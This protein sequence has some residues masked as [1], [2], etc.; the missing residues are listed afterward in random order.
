MHYA[1]K[2]IAIT[3]TIGIWLCS[4]GALFAADVT[5]TPGVVIR[6]TYDDNLFLDNESDLETRFSPTISIESETQRSSL[7]L[8]A[9]ANV[10]RYTH[11]KD[12]NRI[13]YS[14]NVN[15]AYA[16]SP[17]IT[18]GA[19]AKYN[20]DDSFS[21]ELETTGRIISAVTRWAYAGQTS[22]SFTLDR[23]NSLTYSIGGGITRYEQDKQLKNDRL[24]SSLQW[25]HV[26]TPRTS[27]LSTLSGSIEHAYD[28]TQDILT[29]YG[30]FLAGFQYAFRENL[31]LSMQGGATLVDTRSKQ[32]LIVSQ[33]NN[34]GDIE[35]FYL[36]EEKTTSQN[37]HFSANVTLNWQPSKTSNLSATFS[38]STGQDINAVQ[39]TQ[40]RLNLSAAKDITERL[41]VS[42]STSGFVTQ[43]D[44]GDRSGSLNLFLTPAISYR[45]AEDTSISLNYSYYRNWDTLQWDSEWRNRVYLEL[46]SNWPFKP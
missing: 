29:S 33:T 12:Y 26:L 30:R 23:R 20:Q 39:Y 32:K 7:R 11:L 27:L 22:L 8:N 40:S 44:S 41:K 14:A 17:T 36:G 35:E 4:C 43:Y 1:A 38:E 9:Q 19:T 3:A 10:F 46:S 15:M 21:E 25:T 28:D 37:L 5:I 45:L 31:S 24:D 6:E 34:S 2:A 16:I 13:E 18:W 42:L